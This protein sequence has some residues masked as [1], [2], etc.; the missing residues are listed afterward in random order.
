M[1]DSRSVAMEKMLAKLVSSMA[2]SK[3]TSE[4]SEEEMDEKNESDNSNAVSAK[5]PG[6]VIE[7]M[8]MPNRHHKNLSRINMQEDDALRDKEKNTR[9]NDHGEAAQLTPN[10]I[11]ATAKL[12]L[13]L[14][15]G[16]KDKEDD[17]EVSNNAIN[18]EDSLNSYSDDEGGD[19]FLEEDLSIHEE[20]LTLGDKYNTLLEVSSGVF[21]V[22][23]SNQF[24]KTNNFK[25]L[26]WNVAGPS[27]GRM[28]IL[29]NLLKDNLEADQVGLPT[30]FN[31]VP[32]KLLELIVRDAGDDHD[33]QIRFIKQIMEELK[34]INQTTSCN[35]ASSLDG[36][37][38]QPLEAS[39]TQGMLP[40]AHEAS[41]T[42]EAA[43]EPSIM[44]GQDKKG[45]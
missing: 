43:I 5:K 39:K 3:V 18:R 21:D 7:G 16:D 22:T 14:L 28:I 13:S 9:E 33:D 15:D 24:K 38:G 31:R 26:F 23:H 41:P 2:T 44:A 37:L 10:M 35:K 17:K 29:L 1:G 12:N 32:M 6:V 30:D 42:E 20:D 19:D 40:G 34:Q 11:T 25:Q 45:V 4:G 36:G 8:Q 27:P